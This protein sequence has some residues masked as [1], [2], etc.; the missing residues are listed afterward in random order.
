M[1]RPCWIC[2]RGGNAGYPSFLTYI[3]PTL[4]FSMEK[5]KT[6]NLLEKKGFTTHIISTQID[7]VVL[8]NCCD[9]KGG[10]KVSPRNR[11]SKIVNLRPFFDVVHYC[12][13]SVSLSDIWVTR[14]IIITN[15]QWSIQRLSRWVTNY[16]CRDS[17]PAASMRQ[18]PQK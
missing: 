3:G 5:G 13:L 17:G 11:R 15:S 7:A 8:N 9:K 1:Q 14:Q 2:W 10:W 18:C 16:L 12:T 4:L 6:V